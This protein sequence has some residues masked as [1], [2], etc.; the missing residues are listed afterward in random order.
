MSE[1]KARQRLLGPEDAN[2][3]P[4]AA[5]DRPRI[6][7]PHETIEDEVYGA[8]LRPRSFD[9]YVGQERVVENLRIA[10]DAAKRRGEPLEHVL[11]YGPP[12][13]GKTTLAGTDRA[14][15]RRELSPDQR[16][17]AGEAQGSRRHTDRRSKRATSFSSTRFI[18]SAASSKSFSIRRWR[19][20]RSTSSSIAARTPRR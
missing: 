10:I 14:R 5:P 15:A 9:E 6:V 1:P 17:D 3:D 16:A 12:G 19:I 20:F 7:D 11:F 4:A 2:S 8:S 13:L 18:G